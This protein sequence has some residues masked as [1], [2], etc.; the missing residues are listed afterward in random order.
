M[1]VLK[2]YIA[3]NTILNKTTV[4][5]PWQNLTSKAGPFLWHFAQMVLAMEAGMMIY[6]KLLWPL[7]EPTRFGALT[8]TYP[9][10]GYWMMVI[11]MALG[12]LVLMRYRKSTWRSCIEMTGAM[13][14]PLVALTALV[15]F[16]LCPIHILYGFGD[17]LMFLAM[18]AFMIIRPMKHTHVANQHACY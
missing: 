8:D 5:R 3:M 11:S 15:L 6:H 12:M 18:A 16:E 1:F 2:G 13:F 10:L 9:L 7:L 17:P 4:G 14:V